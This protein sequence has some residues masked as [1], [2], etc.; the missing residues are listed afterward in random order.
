M[1]LFSFFVELK[2]YYCAGPAPVAMRS[3]NAR[4]CSAAEMPRIKSVNYF[5]HFPT[6]RLKNR[7][8]RK[9]RRVYNNIM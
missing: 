7:V 9:S 3:E 1:V 8:C 4:F 6:P 5:F 2:R